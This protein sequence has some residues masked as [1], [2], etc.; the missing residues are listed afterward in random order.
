MYVPTHGPVFIQG[1]QAAA[2][3]AAHHGQFPAG[4][5]ITPMTTA[6]MTRGSP[7]PPL[8]PHI[9]HPSP[10]GGPTERP[11][12]QASP[13]HP[14]AT[15]PAAAAEYAAQRAVAAQQT[16]AAEALARQWAG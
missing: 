16:A 7:H 9:S 13:F 15:S 1:H 3:A 11:H 4:H 12:Q 10:H 8:S 6:P 5:L 2:M 14:D